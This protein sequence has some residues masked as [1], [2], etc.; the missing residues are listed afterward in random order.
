[1]AQSVNDTFLSFVAH[2]AWAGPPSP[3]GWRQELT[4]WTVFARQLLAQPNF[5]LYCAMNW[6]MNFNVTLSRNFFVVLDSKLMA[7]RQPF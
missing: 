4:A 7:V 2:R 6:L 5:V 3:V 1:M